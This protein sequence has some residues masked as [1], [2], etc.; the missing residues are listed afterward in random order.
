MEKIK[1]LFFIIF[2]VFIGYS[3]IVPAYAEV[4]SFQTDKS[5]YTPGNKIYFTGTVGIEDY[6]KQVNLVIHNPVGK[7]VLIS[8]NY[9]DS[10]YTF[11]VVV[12]TNDMNQFSTKG[13]Y[14]AIAFIGTQS[15]GKT[16]TF[17]F[18]PDGSP[19]IHQTSQNT[20]IT[21]TT[22]SGQPIAQHYQIQLNE[23]TV[24]NDV[25]GNLTKIQTPS[26]FEKPP[27]QF[28]FKNI[29]YPVISLC[30]VGIVVVVIYFKKINLKLGTQK[31]HGPQQS[32]PTMVSAEP[33]DDYAMLILKNRLAKGEISLD[34]FKA[35]KDT[36]SEL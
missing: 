28:D 14:S 27:N 35:I 7:F 10:I 19:V 13:T 22:K 15:G 5:F 16:I 31:I 29:L 32:T 20:N 30:G 26:T 1:W 8:G 33:E 9:S 2:A 3:S 18:S 11:E 6:Q 4:N 21:G 25:A 34:E 17:D 36:L 12:N 23:S 24:M